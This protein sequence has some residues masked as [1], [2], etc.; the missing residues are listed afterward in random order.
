[1]FYRPH[2]RVSLD[3][4]T[5]LITKQSH[6]A[7]CDIHNILS[8]FQRT[9]I[10]NHIQQ[11]RPEFMDLP[12][13]LDYQTSLNILLEAREAFEAL[14]SSV[15]AH[16]ANDPGQFLAAFS[17]PSQEAYLR[18]HGFLNPKE[19]PSAPSATSPSPAP[20]GT[21]PAST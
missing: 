2:P 7:E 14:P 18:D 6:K 8:Q 15:R 3:C 10:L 17:D 16:F 21:A 1:M 11:R 20:S 9:G 4:G 5:D 13:S 19:G 12:D